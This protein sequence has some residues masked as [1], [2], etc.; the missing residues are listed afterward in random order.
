M[1]T[2]FL[3]TLSL[4]LSL[5]VVNTASA[6]TPGG[7]DNEQTETATAEE[8][9]DSATVQAMAKD[10]CGCLKQKVSDDAGQKETIKKLQTCFRNNQ[11]AQK[12]MQKKGRS[13]NRKLIQTM[14]QTCPT[15]M[16]PLQQRRR[17]GGR[18][19]GRQGG[20]QGGSQG[21]GGQR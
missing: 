5:G 2:L 4:F 12:R 14:G 3:M 8:P 1:R 15:V 13:F 21:G 18:Q 20:G 7:E 17:G 16:K 19:G 11:A 10:I 9:G 6:T